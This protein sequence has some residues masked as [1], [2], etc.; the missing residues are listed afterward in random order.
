LRNPYEPPKAPI[1]VPVSP[2]PLPRSVRVL[3]MLAIIGSVFLGLIPVLVIIA[4]RPRSAEL[5]VMLGVSAIVFLLSGASI[6]SLVTRLSEGLFF[7]GAML[8]NGLA[9]AFL[10]YGFFSGG[11]RSNAEIALIFVLPVLLN[12]VAIDQLRRARVAKA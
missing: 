10:L 2:E 8:L 3:R 12:M 9:A 4:T 1:A 11:G 6:A 7:W 5:V